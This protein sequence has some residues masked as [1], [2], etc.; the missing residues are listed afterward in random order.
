MANKTAARLMVSFGNGFF[1]LVVLSTLFGVGLSFTK[2]RNFE[3]VGASKIG[4]LFLYVLVATI[5]MKMDIMEL[6]ANWG[7]FKFL[8]SIGLIWIMVHAYSYL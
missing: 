4:S 8:L 5:G 7:V 6:I 3:G 1:W 2:Y